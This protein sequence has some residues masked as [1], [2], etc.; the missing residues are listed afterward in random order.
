MQI[1]FTEPVYLWLLLAIPFLVFSHYLSLKHARFRGMRFANFETLRRVSGSHQ[2]TK[3]SFQ[4]LIRVVIFI[5]II[6]SVSSP[7]FWYTAEASESDVVIAIDNS[8]SMS[9]ED[10]PPSRLEVAKSFSNSL[11]DAFAFETTFSVISF[12][13]VPLVRSVYE[14]NKFATKDAINEIKVAKAS[15]TDIPGTIISATNL[16]LNNP[17]KAKIIILITDG[18]NTYGPFLSDSIKQSGAY[19]TQNQVRIHSIGIGTDE[20]LVGY[21]PEYYNVSAVYQ[22]DALTELANIT[23]GSYFHLETLEDVQEA[24]AT[25]PQESTQTLLKREL[26]FYL[27][28]FALF[29]LF[30]EWGLLN[31]RF[32]RVV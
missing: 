31:T 17:E 9:A 30:I 19:A 10:L 24:I 25:I 14:T 8:A 18:G 6:L 16:L 20:G 2:L 4:L 15:G 13:G 28:L 27:M 21:L 5:A 26:S 29:M 22:D 23:D 11:V 1:S 12:S 3:N 7:V 32:R